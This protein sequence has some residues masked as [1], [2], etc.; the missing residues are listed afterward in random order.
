MATDDVASITAAANAASP[1]HQYTGDV[2]PTIAPY[3]GS[4]GQST[5]RNAKSVDPA[6][7]PAVPRTPTEMLGASYWVS[8]GI[9]KP[10]DPAVSGSTWQNV[11]ILPPATLRRGF[12]DQ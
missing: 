4:P 10:V 8:A 9:N 1:G 3:V 11:R 6:A 12:Y 5:P 2:L 7:Q